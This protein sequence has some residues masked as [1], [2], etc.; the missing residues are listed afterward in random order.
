VKYVRN[1]LKECLEI[2]HMSEWYVYKI[3]MKR[4]EGLDMFLNSSVQ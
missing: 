4:L 1:A 2:F 3:S